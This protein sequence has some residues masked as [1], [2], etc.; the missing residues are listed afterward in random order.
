MGLRGYE[1]L[2]RKHEKNLRSEDYTK[3]KS[4]NM[5]V[6]DTLVMND[7]LFCKT[8]NLLL[9]KLRKYRDGYVM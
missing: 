7:K 6:S 9:H 1:L 3:E 8:N 2:T 4:S 5:E